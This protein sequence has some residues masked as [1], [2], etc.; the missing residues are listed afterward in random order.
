MQ[1]E[2][3][4]PTAQVPVALHLTLALNALPGN[5]NEKAEALGAHR[6]TLHRWTTGKTVPREEDWARLAGLLDVPL[7]VLRYGPTPVLRSCLPA[8]KPSR[9]EVVGMSG[10]VGEVAASTGYKR[11][12]ILRWRRA[13]RR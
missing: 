12:T 5:L 9:E 7:P 4:H 13:A 6:T 8:P 2:T 1:P 3:P 11:S 10:T